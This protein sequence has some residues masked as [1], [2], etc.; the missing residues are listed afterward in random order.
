MATRTERITAILTNLDAAATV[1]T[2]ARTK[3]VTGAFAS[4]YGASVLPSI[5]P[6]TYTDSQKRGVFLR[7]LARFIREVCQGVDANA[8]AEAARTAALAAVD[9]EFGAEEVV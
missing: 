5:D 3:Q 9:A 6:K 2:A 8:A 1:P 4:A 7:I